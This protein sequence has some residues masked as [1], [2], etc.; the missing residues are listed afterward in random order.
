MTSKEQA[1]ANQSSTGSRP[2]V[3]EMLQRLRGIRV[4]LSAVAD[5]VDDLGAT[6]LRW[7]DE[8]PAR[9]HAKRVREPGPT[10]P[11]AGVQVPQGQGQAASYETTQARRSRHSRR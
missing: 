8:Q 4:M 1:G 10:T 11:V 6:M 3:A 7:V 2:L 5:E 9:H